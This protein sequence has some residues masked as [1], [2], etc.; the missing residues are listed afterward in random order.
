[1]RRIDERVAALYVLLAHPVFHLLAD[2]PAL[3][4]PENQSRPRQFLNREQIKLLPDH[5][6]IAL[7]GFLDLL[8]MRIKILLREKRSPV[9]ALQLRIL[10]IPQPVSPRD[11]EQFER[12]DF[13]SRRNM[14]PAAEIN[15]LSRA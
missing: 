11:V 8:Q 3:G 10:L 14:R 12:L 5:A 15:K 6:M 7:L 2:D 13:S 4:M 9:N 1:M